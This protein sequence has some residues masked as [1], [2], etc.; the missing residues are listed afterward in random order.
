VHAV[1]SHTIFLLRLACVG[2]TSAVRS[3]GGFVNTRLTASWRSFLLIAG[4]FVI[5]TAALV[6]Q[7][8]ARGGQTAKPAPGGHAAA[9]AASADAPATVLQVMRAILFPSSNVVFSAQAD[10][11]AAVKKASDPSTATDPLA[12]TYGGWEAVANSAIALK[13]SARLL[14]VPRS[15]SNGKPA[16]IQT[17]TWKK[18]LTQLREAGQAAYKAAQ[19][20]NQDQVLDAAEKITTACSTCHDPYRE[21]TPRCS[22]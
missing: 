2:E 15:C 16:P 13:E 11:P 1:Y 7:A 22:P 18:G 8:P 12:S 19:A 9:P 5:A 10:D 20:K 4:S 21:K 6:A 3:R 14:E 17:A